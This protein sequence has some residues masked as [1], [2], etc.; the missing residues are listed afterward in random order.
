METGKN[1]KQD[2]SEKLKQ[3]SSKTI[4]TEDINKLKNTVPILRQ[5]SSENQKTPAFA[6]LVKLMLEMAN[7][8]YDPAKKY[9]LMYKII[10][11]GNLME[12]LL[13]DNVQKEANAE[14]L[15]KIPL[16]KS[17]S[18]LEF[19]QQFSIFKSARNIV[20]DGVHMINE[21]RTTDYL[22][23]YSRLCRGE[24]VAGFFGDQHSWFKLINRS[25]DKKTLLA[26]GDQ[27]RINKIFN[28]LVY[29]LYK[30]HE[31]MLDKNVQGAIMALIAAADC[32]R[33]IKRS[34]L[35]LEIKN[36]SVLAILTNLRQDLAHIYKD[37]YDEEQFRKKVSKEVSEKSIQSYVASIAREAKS[38][39]VTI[40]VS[41]YKKD[42]ASKQGS[43]RAYEEEVLQALAP[44]IPPS[45][46]LFKSPGGF[47]DRGRVSEREPEQKYKR[48]KSSSEKTE[49]EKDKDKGEKDRSSRIRLDSERVIDTGKD[50]N[51]KKE[52]EYNPKKRTED[53]KEESSKKDHE[54]KQKKQR[55]E[56]SSH[57]EDE[58]KYHQEDDPDKDQGFGEGVSGHKHFSRSTGYTGL[59]VYS[60]VKSRSS[61]TQR[62]DRNVKKTA[63]KEH[64]F[65]GQVPGKIVQSL[66]IS[67]DRKRDWESVES[68][69][70]KSDKEPS[71]HLQDHET[72]KET[73]DKSKSL[74]AEPET[75]PLVNAA[76][77]ISLGT[78]HRKKPF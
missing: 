9:E 13:L 75:K 37:D 24:N 5:I 16:D 4:N 38:L 59:P 19:N 31:L 15:K 62:D 50:K 41:S 1:V 74:K 29:F 70:T 43:P 3:I 76:E 46:N 42:S 21:E 20:A 12:L 55:K 28:Q 35:L 56:Y 45:P 72:P 48:E 61:S 10:E 33:D 64:E 77:T 60:A 54:K 11:I 30:S 39:K 36:D 52:K 27:N 78:S 49:T 7:V 66:N 73:K 25:L 14:T 65:Y 34:G 6:K 44:K 63:L 57:R 8:K 51:S 22:Q 40:D 58:L 68:R 26:S 47:S 17:F 69:S 67:R 23:N 71:S 18:T 53:V 2:V 32:A